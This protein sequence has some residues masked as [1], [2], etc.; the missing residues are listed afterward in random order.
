MYR[1]ISGYLET[2]VN[3]YELALENVKSRKKALQILTLYIHTYI[4]ISV[5]SLRCRVVV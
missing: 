1:S 4:Y 5:A 2:L 3:I